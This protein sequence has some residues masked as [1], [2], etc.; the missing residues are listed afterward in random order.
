MK[1]IIAGIETNRTKKRVRNSALI[2][3][4][5][6]LALMLV[7]S[8]GCASRNGGSDLPPS[9]DPAIE[10]DLLPDAEGNQQGDIPDAGE[11]DESGQLNNAT[12]TDNGSQSSGNKTT[13]RTCTISISCATILNNMDL[14][15][16][17]KIDLIPA[18]GWIL[19]E[20]SVTFDEGESVFDVLKRTCRQERIHMEYNNVPLYNSAY[21]EG[22]HN[23]YEFDCGPLS[24][25]MYSVNGYFPN[26]GS[27]RYA[28]KDGDVI[29]WMYS[30]DLGDDVGGSNFDSN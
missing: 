1:K 16:P 7:I 21:I 4:S 19:K 3:L 14:L 22:L 26:Y 25:W 9:D 11:S 13:A 2:F 18:D 23:L 20:I 29:R 17:N 8:T 12:D 24:G 28:L 30:C 10:T 5:L 15:D 6:I 27:S